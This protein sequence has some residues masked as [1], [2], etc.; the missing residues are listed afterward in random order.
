VEQSASTVVVVLLVAAVVA[1]ALGD[2]KD[3]A[4]ILATLVLLGPGDLLAADLRLTESWSL[5]VN[6]AALPASPSR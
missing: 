3:T 4:V 1:A 5:R 2:L 6:E